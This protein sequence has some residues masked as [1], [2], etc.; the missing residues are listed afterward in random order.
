MMVG[1][2]MSACSAKFQKSLIS[3]RL[4]QLRTAIFRSSFVT[5]FGI[6]RM[7]RQASLSD[8]TVN[9]QGTLYISHIR[10]MLLCGETYSLMNSGD[11]QC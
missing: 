5:R 3:V 2:R 10:S 7:Q 6:G 11:L 4:A 9:L 1:R 8:M